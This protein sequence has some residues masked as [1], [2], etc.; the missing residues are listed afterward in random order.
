MPIPVVAATNQAE[1]NRPSCTLLPTG[2]ADGRNPSRFT[3]GRS[4][5]G[6]GA[7]IP[8]RTVTLCRATQGRAPG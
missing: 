4:S 5:D 2:A 3:S 7:N 6:M 1:P 8:I